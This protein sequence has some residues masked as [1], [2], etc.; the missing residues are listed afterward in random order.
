MEFA[1]GKI[2]TMPEILANHFTVYMF[3]C[4]LYNLQPRTY[5]RPPKDTVKLLNIP[6]FYQCSIVFI[7]IKKGANYE[8]ILE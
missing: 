3:I 6:Q 2:S 8:T 7:G 1:V 4:S 5:Q